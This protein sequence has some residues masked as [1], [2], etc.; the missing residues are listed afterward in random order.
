MKALFLFSFSLFG[1]LSLKGA[2]IFSDNFDDNTNSGWTYLNRNGSSEI[3]DAV[4]VETGG[5]L[6]QQTTNY[7][8][9][10]DTTVNDPVL[11]A[12]ALA[13]V[14]V[15]GIYSVSADF[16]SLEPGNQFQDQDMVFGYQSAGQFFIVETI[17]SGLNLFSVV[18]GERSIVGNGSISFSH[19]PTSLLVE[20]NANLG[21][22]TLTYGEAAPVTYT[23]PSLVMAGT[24]S[25]GVGSNN[26]AFAVDNFVVTQIPEPSVAGFLGLSLF[27][28]GLRRR[29]S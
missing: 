5:R 9:P 16:T 23:D 6:E 2:V 11:G 3:A 25:V 7:D 12:I 22:V 24:G 8:F 26:D 27:F 19:S 17:P 18:G 10:R 15:G 20:H 21:E 14:T 1:A 29:Q 13:P 28:L 4:W